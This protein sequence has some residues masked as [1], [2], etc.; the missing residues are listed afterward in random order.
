[1]ISPPI[2]VLPSVIIKNLEAPLPLFAGITLSAFNTL[3]LGGSDNTKNI[4]NDFWE[5]RT[6]IIIDED[7]KESSLIRID[8]I[9]K[10]Y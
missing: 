1:M 6:W 10:L 9:Q 8:G 4:D 2:T 3:K 7:S 5:S